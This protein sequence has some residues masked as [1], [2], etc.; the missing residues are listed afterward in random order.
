ME[1]HYNKQLI[2]FL[3]IKRIRSQAWNYCNFSEFWQINLILAVF[4]KAHLSILVWWR[5][6]PGFT[7]K[8]KFNSVI[9]LHSKNICSSQQK[10]IILIHALSL[11]HFSYKNVSSADILFNYIIYKTLLLYLS[12]EFYI[13]LQTFLTLRNIFLSRSNMQISPWSRAQHFSC[14]SPSTRCSILWVSLCSTLTAQMVSVYFV[15][16]MAGWRV[17]T[18]IALSVCSITLLSSCRGGGRTASL[19]SRA[20]WNRLLLNDAAH[21]VWKTEVCESVGGDL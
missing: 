13:F 9:S 16:G 14:F 20:W 4:G 3:I 8:K 12:Q 5:H 15:R 1:W 10:Q 7:K 21:V 11:E 6:R 2:S 19:R 18:Q 17:A